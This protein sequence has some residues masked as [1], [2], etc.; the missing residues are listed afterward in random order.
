MS[1]V[2]DLDSMALRSGAVNTIVAHGERL[3]GHNTDIAGLTTDLQQWLRGEVPDHALVLGAG[4]AARAAVLALDALGV[5]R[6]TIHNRSGGS[7]RRLTAELSTECE[8][9]TGLAEASLTL[10]ATSLGVGCAPGTDAFLEAHAYWTRIPMGDWAYDLSYAPAPTPFLAAA[11]RAG[12]SHTTD[13]RG[14]LL[15]QGAES[16]QLWTGRA[17]PIKVM[18]GALDEALQWRRPSGSVATP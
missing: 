17:A 12:A 8:L 6:V 5:Q 15:H 7:A 9:A 3:E 13:G 18:R 10:H 14:M 4:G 11:A 2:D 16:F 1:L